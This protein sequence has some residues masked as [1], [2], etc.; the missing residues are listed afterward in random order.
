M[1]FLHVSGLVVV[2]CR[3]RIHSCVSLITRLPIIVVLK[4]DAQNG[5]GCFSSIP[6]HGSGDG[7]VNQECGWKVVWKPSI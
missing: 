6:R 4:T 1:R 7:I 2:K 5:H 3:S